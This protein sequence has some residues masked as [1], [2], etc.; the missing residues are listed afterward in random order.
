MPDRDVQYFSV[1][2]FFVNGMNERVRQFV[3]MDEAI[4]V[5]KHYSSNV[6]VRMGITTRV[7]ITDAMDRTVYEWKQGEGVVWPKKSQGE[8]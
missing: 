7:I 6:A 3:P 2:Q 4:A 8:L 5:A 1:Y